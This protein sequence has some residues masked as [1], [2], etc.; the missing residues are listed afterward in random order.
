MPDTAAVTLAEEKLAEAHSEAAMAA[1]DHARTIAYARRELG[2]A[3]RLQEGPPPT[4]GPWIR[5][6]LDDADIAIIRSAAL[7]V[8]I[9]DNKAGTP[10]Q[11]VE[12]LRHLPDNLAAALVEHWRA[13]SDEVW[14]CKELNHERQIEQLCARQR[15][16]ITAHECWNHTHP[17]EPTNG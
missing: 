8:G 1:S 5:P 16:L 11:N 9:E 15:E 7:A 13:L 14:R 2:Y 17:Q 6:H 12:M 10:E 3:L 4:E